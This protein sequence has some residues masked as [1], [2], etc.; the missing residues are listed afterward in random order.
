MAL[1]LPTHE[2]FAGLRLHQ[3]LPA[4][5]VAP[6]AN[7]EY[8]EHSWVGEG[9]VFTCVL[10][11]QAEPGR[12]RAINIDLCETADRAEEV[13]ARLLEAVG[14]PLQRGMDLQTI[15]ERLGGVL[16]VREFAF[17]TDRRTYE[18]QLGGGD[19]RRTY[20]LLCTI[21]HVGGLIFVTMNTP[22]PSPEE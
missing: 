3:F 11:L 10:Q 6:L 1:S 14:L 15:V 17:A 19:P 21:T 18:F 13:G 12:T 20:E 2:Q 16:P 8:L 4:A 5:A 7:W 9:H 22:L